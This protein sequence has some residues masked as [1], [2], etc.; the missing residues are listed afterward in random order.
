MALVLLIGGLVFRWSAFADLKAI[1]RY[2][3]Y[4]EQ[5]SID[6]QQALRRQEWLKSAKQGKTELDQ[7]LNHKE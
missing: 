2:Q 1:K 5:Q 7:K 4:L 6:Q 3:Q